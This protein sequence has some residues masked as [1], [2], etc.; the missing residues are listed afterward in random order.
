MPM[1]AGDHVR[2]LMSRLPG[3]QEMEAMT[4]Y[5]SALRYLYAKHRWLFLL[6]SDVVTTEAPYSDG[7]VQVTPA[8]AAIVG[9]GTAWSA[10]W[11]NRRIVIQGSATVLDVVVSGAGT[12]TLQAGGVNY[13]W[14]GDAASGLTYRMFRDV[15]LLSSSF[16]WG[17]EHFWWDAQQQQELPM[18][19][20]TL[21]LREKAQVPGTLGQPSA[22]C[23]AALQQ[24]SPTTAPSA[25]VE[26]GPYVPDAV[27]SYDFW[28]FRNPV[29][30]TSDNDYPLWPEG[31]ERLI[32]DRMEI[33]Y[34]SNPRHRIALS[35]EFMNEYRNR[36]WDCM[37]RNDGGA[38]ITRVRARYRG[39]RGNVGPFANVRVAP[40]PQGWPVS[41]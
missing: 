36:M 22:V 26:F 41:G 28:G 12:A 40:D 17:R 5:S 33:E 21:M 35:P 13:L 31:Y 30:A 14:P 7:T 19:D 2:L 16:D 38:E 29:I 24:A 8:S 25:A 27:Y 23:R 3:L 37:K 20:V 10:A 4:L 32:S 15:Y 39:G 1:R 6:K 34:A 9:T 18:V 11:A